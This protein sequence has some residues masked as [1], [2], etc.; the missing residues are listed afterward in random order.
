MLSLQGVTRRYGAVEAVAEVDLEIRRGEFFCLLGPSGSGKTTLL[1]LIAGFESPD[2]GTLVIEGVPA[3]APP[4]RRDIGF[5]FHDYALFPHRTVSENVGF[6]LKMRG[7]RPP[8]RRERVEEMLELVGLTALADRRP[9]TLSAGQRQRVALA[10]ALAPSPRLLLLDE[11][12]AN[13]DRRLRESLRA[14]LVRI[15]STVGVTTVLVTH[16]QEE[17]LMLADRVG[18]M[19]DG[20]LEQVGTPVELWTRPASRFVAGFVGDM[21]LLGATTDGPGTAEIS[22]LQARVTVSEASPGDGP[23][24]AC[25]RPEARLLT[26]PRTGAPGRV[27]AV[28]YGGGQAAYRVELAGGQTVL[29]RESLA[30]GRPGWS[31]GDEVG[32]TVRDVVCRLL[33]A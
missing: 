17:A 1:R 30:D 22:C 21:N 31:T 18:V 25:I 15:Q 7:R 5:V 14:E 29:V 19:G 33:P 20:R 4:E 11:P 9:G 8:E 32:V 23:L 6:G 10:R 27:A 2:G 24:V 28:A 12:L 16:D 13:L 26:D 3:D